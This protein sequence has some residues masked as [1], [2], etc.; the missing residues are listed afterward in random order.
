MKK[1][2]SLIL[3]L[4]FA[5]VSFANESEIDMDS[6]DISTDISS[7]ESAASM[8]DSESLPLEDFASSE[9]VEEL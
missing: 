5:S 6:N 4:T 7:D 1:L 9:D 2:M 8:D 3:L